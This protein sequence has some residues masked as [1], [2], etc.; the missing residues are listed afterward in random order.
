M[1]NEYLVVIEGKP[2]GPFSL[3]QLKEMAI[4][5]GTFVKTTG[6]SDY[7][8][9]HEVPEL[10]VLLGFSKVAAQP[11][12]FATLDQRL[13]AVVIDYLIIIAVHAILVTVVII[14]SKDQQS[15]ILTAI[16]ALLLAPFTKIVYSAIMES[17]VRQATFGKSMIG[18]KVCDESGN[19]VSVN[20]A[21][22]RNLA[23]L[24][25]KLT[26]GIGYLSGFFDKRQQCLHDKI[27]GTLVI[28][29][30]LL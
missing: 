3:Q 24:I 22:A 1:A 17:S 30:R 26:L 7:K 9:A 13:L 23:K 2:E 4:S 28:K 29:E 11:Q 8:E 18:L 19:R 16:A 5:P 14:F 10:R 27:A 25:S 21:F 6:M 12:Y 20:R 15:K